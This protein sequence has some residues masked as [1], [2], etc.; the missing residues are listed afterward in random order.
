[1]IAHAL[2]Q[3]RERNLT[4]TN[5][6]PALDSLSIGNVTITPALNSTA[7]AAALAVF[8]ISPQNAKQAQGEPTRSCGYFLHT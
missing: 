8:G 1:M 4:V 6:G 2:L 3:A 7:H 5:A